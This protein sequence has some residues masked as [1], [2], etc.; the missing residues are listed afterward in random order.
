MSKDSDKGNNQTHDFEDV[1]SCIKGM[2]RREFCS[3]LVKRAA[4]AGT[5]AVA[6]TSVNFHDHKAIASA[7]GMS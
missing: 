5:L 6:L 2:S 4:V 3:R 1:D 7:T